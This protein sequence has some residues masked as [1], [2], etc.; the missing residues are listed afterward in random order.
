M[1][2][3]L[4]TFIFM[5]I[6]TVLN[7]LLIIIFIILALLLINF[8]SKFLSSDFMFFIS[9]STFLTAIILSFIVYNRIILYV[10]KKYNLND[11]LDPI[12]KPKNKNDK[13]ITRK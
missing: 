12:F 13:N 11:K 8:A 3:K 1:N 7:I 5:I 2:K 9:I 10:T 6:A 4:N